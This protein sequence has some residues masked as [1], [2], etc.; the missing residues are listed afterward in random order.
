MAFV[1]ARDLN[2]ETY[3]LHYDEYT[4]RF[5]ETVRELL[6]FLHLT[7]KSEPEPFIQGKVYR[8]EY[9]TE[10]ERKNVT[11]A[12]AWMAS[13]TAWEHLSRYFEQ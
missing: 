7:A 2:L 13:P 1:V 11:E 9:F 12:V 4:T 10:E 3:V 5:D 6:E 8:A